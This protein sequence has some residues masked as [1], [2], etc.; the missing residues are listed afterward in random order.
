MPSSLQSQLD[1][2]CAVIQSLAVQAD[3]IERIA[4]RACET[5]LAGRLLLT[6]G[7]GG[8]ATEAQ[9]LA[10]AVGGEGPAGL[11]TRYEVQEP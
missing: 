6:C 11:A 9:H 10:E 4:A 5:L 1:V 7:N 2:S 3:L 8:S